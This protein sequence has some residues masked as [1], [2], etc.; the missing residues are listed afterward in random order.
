MDGGDFLSFGEA[1]LM[2]ESLQL[3]KLER[4]GGKD[5][6][7]QHEYLTK[8]NQQEGSSKFIITE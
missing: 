4:I 8:L 3:T 7:K 6:K 5:W 1:E 2:V